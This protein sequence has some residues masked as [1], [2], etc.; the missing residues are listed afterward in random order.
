MVT[1]ARGR[2]EPGSKKI[3][4]GVAIS[5]TELC[6][7]DIRLRGASDRV[8]RAPLD[9]PPS[10]GAN[11]PSLA[12]A[13]AALARELGVTSG[14]LVISLMPPLTEVR[15]LELPPLRD[16]DL[17]RLLLR[18][19]SRYFVGARA[20]QIVGAS[21]A[22]RRTRGAPA[23]VVAAAAS[24]RLMAMI[25]VAAEQTGWTVDAVAPAETAWAAAAIAMWPS[26]ARQN[27]HALIAHDDRTD[28]LQIENGRLAGVRRFRAGGADAAMIA[29]AVGP[30]PR[31]GVAGT[32]QPRRVLTSALNALGLSTSIAGGEWASVAENG[33]GLAAY[34]AG[35]DVGPVLRSEASVATQRARTRKATMI[36]FA[37]AAALVVASA[38]I[39]LWGVHHQLN[40]VR[41]QRAQLRPALSSTL[42]GRTTVEATYRH[43]AALNGIERSTPQWAAVITTLSKAIPND[44]YL[45]AIRSRDDSLIVD[46][47]AEHAARVFDALEK[48]P[49]LTDVKAAAA[50]RRDLQDDG[51]ALDHFTIAARVVANPPGRATTAPVS[52]SASPKVGQ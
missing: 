20:A 16:D 17:Q 34:F 6:A 26:L 7:V 52:N 30:S 9:A 41:Q 19:S 27:L 32:V 1:R 40:L 24:A 33:D 43:L 4:T 14:T 15:Q 49:G 29:D 21:R 18:N 48:T 5:A 46:G 51:T 8:W 11:W 31:I 42:I 25:H 3:Q 28:L 13:F 10:E 37:S 22:V 47:L 2:G 35:S 38:A 39:E 12:S 50:V 36:T 44:A 45:T 23:P